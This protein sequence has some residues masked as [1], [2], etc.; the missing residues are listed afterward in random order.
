MI[1]VESPN[2]VKVDRP[3]LFLCGGI[4]ECKDWQKIVVSRLR[5][6]DIIVF[7]PR[8]AN[9]GTI[10]EGVEEEQ[11]TWEEE[12]IKKA[13]ILSFYFCRE[14]LCPITLY[15]L[16]TGNMTKKHMLI[17]MDED[18]ARKKDVI[19]QTH[20]KRPEVPIIFGLDS[21]ILSLTEMCISIL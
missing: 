7:N 9:Y 18:Y 6:L 20:L 17:G 16:G 14:T 15:E 3:S 5:P 12:K 1:Y 2:R 8:R 10:I 21:F 4:S 13:D 19:I 11:I